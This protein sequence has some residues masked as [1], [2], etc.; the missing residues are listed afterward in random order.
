MNREHPGKVNPILAK[1]SRDES[2]R[3]SPD[4]PYFLQCL[5]LLDTQESFFW[6]WF[7][8]SL[9]A[10]VFWD[11]MHMFGSFCVRA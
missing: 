8:K 6:A 7:G 10:S 1:R 11:N 5:S 9:F 3:I 4:N 2:H